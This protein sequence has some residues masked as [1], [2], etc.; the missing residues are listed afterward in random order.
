M[1]ETCLPHK[2][3]TFSHFFQVAPVLLSG[4][5]NEEGSGQVSWLMLYCSLLNVLAFHRRQAPAYIWS[6][7]L[8]A[9]EL[10]ILRSGDKQWRLEHSVSDTVPSTGLGSPSLTRGSIVTISIGG[11]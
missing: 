7:L 2:E 10:G 6:T 5:Y 9:C 11:N 8:T 4:G 1:M 3:N